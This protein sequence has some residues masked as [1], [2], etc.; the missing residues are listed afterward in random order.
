MQPQLGFSRDHISLSTSAHY[1]SSFPPTRLLL[2]KSGF[3]VYHDI[4]NR[5]STLAMRTYKH[6][7]LSHSLV[8]L[9]ITCGLLSYGPQIF[10]VAGNPTAHDTPSG[11][12]IPRDGP[13]SI[14]NQNAAADVYGLGVRLGFYLQ[15]FTQLLHIIPLRK[16]SGRGVKLACASIAISILASWSILAADKLISPCE[17]FLVTFILNSV[18]LPAGLAILNPDAIVGEGIG[19]MLFILTMVWTNVATTWTYAKLWHTLPLLDTKNVVF[20]FA[21]VSVTGGFRI[22]ALLLSLFSWLL[23]LAEV[24]FFLIIGKTALRCYFKGMNEISD[25]DRKRLKES[26]MM[27][28]KVVIMPLL[29]RIMRKRGLAPGPE[30]PIGSPPE[31]E[32]TRKTLGRLSWLLPIGLLPAAIFSW[33]LLIVMA[34]KTISLNNLSPATDLSAPGQLI[35]LVAGLSVALDSVFFICRPSG[36]EGGSVEQFRANINKCVLI[37][38]RLCWSI[39]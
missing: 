33:A 26:E 9:A 14:G 20:F 15:G 36:G 13:D 22:F 2:D 7:R 34:E 25:E 5:N 12:I 38:I 6:T 3:F 10:G 37:I 17:A 28:I 19:L 39:S 30:F 24:P 23:L 29:K 16:D 35:P 11:I 4:R 1:P 31:R 32:R 27:A 18:S 8:V 21:P